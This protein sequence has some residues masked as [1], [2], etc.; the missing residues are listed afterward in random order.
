MIRKLAMT[1]IAFSTML[2]AAPALAKDPPPPPVTLEKCSASLGTIA[3][4]GDRRHD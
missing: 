2:V 3:M 1:T 4:V